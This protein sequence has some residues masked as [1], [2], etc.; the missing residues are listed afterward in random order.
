[1]K[2]IKRE[3]IPET[4]TRITWVNAPCW[5]D[6]MDSLFE[7]GED[8]LSAKLPVKGGMVTTLEGKDGR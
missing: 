7:Q 5:P 1:M 8:V 4:K 6:I 2:R 3:I